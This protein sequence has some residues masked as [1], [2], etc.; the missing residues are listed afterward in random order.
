MSGG[1]VARFAARCGQR[2]SCARVQVL[3]QRT[4]AVRAHTTARGFAT[5]QRFV[6][7]TVAGTH[8][9]TAPQC[10]AARHMSVSHGLDVIDDP[11]AEVL[12]TAAKPVPNVGA[13]AVWK[14]V[15]RML[16]TCA[17]EPALGLAAPQV[18]ESQRIFVMRTPRTFYL[19]PLWGG[20]NA[21]SYMPII[22]P[23]VTAR[24]AQLLLGPESCLSMPGET[25][26]VP[27]HT[28]ISVKYLTPKGEERAHSLTGLPAIVFQHE[29]DHLDGVLMCD[30]AVTEQEKDKLKAQGKSFE[31][32]EE[33]AYAR[34]NESIERDFLWE[35]GELN[36]D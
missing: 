2:L 8:G 13:P 18:G 25:F 29:L 12:R 5:L 21:M 34:Y 17:A 16:H 6:P 26:M 24:S 20:N 32:M 9:I 19:H 15:E 28:V 1:G 33:R 4:T 27:R 10:V 35:A 36:R 11:T 23:V 22:N 14:L 30:R 31:D 7:P 3:C